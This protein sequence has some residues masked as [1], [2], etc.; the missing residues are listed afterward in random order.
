MKLKIK[1]RNKEKEKKKINDEQRKI[2]EI[3]I[4]KEREITGGIG[5]KEIERQ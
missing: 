4:V 3:R 5:E 1:T 2:E